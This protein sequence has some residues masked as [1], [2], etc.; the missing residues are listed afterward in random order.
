[1]SVEPEQAAARILAELEQT[2]VRIIAE[3]EQAAARVATR[4]SAPPPNEPPLAYLSLKQLALYS[5]LGV[6]TLRARL[7]DPHNPLPHQK[8][9]D[10][11]LV[12]VSAFDAWMDGFR[13]TGP[14]LP[15]HLQPVMV[16]ARELTAKLKVS[17]GT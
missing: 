13:V 14:Q 11:V 8:V 15:A 7:R 16:R 2:A 9:G 5:G 3:L 10:R 4:V 1:M 6:R 17:K 12:R